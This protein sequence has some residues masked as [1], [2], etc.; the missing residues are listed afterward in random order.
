M[1]AYFYTTVIPPRLRKRYEAGLMHKD[2]AP[3]LAS[4]SCVKATWFHPWA[5]SIFVIAMCL[6]DFFQGMSRSYE[7][8]VFAE[9]PIFRVCLMAIVRGGLFSMAMVHA[10]VQGRYSRDSDDSTNPLTRHLRGG[11]ET[12]KVDRKFSSYGFYGR[13]V[14]SMACTF[15]SGF[16][17]YSVFYDYLD[18]TFGHI[19]VPPM[20]HSGSSYVACFMYYYSPAYTEHDAQVCL[21]TGVGLTYF[22]T[23]EHRDNFTMHG[24]PFDGLLNYFAEWWRLS[25]RKY[26]Q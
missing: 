13:L 14:L 7:P 9:F 19:V 21:A 23:A 16:F 1:G 10:H 5:L 2:R 17:I 3:A 22:P 24:Q 12:L 11:I 26:Y 18:K 20:M 25:H 8:T 6:A 4:P 15:G